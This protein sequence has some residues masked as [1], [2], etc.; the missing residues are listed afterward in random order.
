MFNDRRN[1]ARALCSLFRQKHP[2]AAF[3]SKTEVHF[4]S[5]STDFFRKSTRSSTQEPFF[6]K[7][8][9]IKNFLK[10]RLAERWKKLTSAALAKR[11][12]LVKRTGRELSQDISGETLGSCTIWY[13]NTK[14]PQKF[15]IWCT[16]RVPMRFAPVLKESLGVI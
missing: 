13:S 12:L 11:M 1:R 6:Q 3:L 9:N 15:K 16:Q 4:L 14:S 5:M 2:S 8:A 10:S 7:E